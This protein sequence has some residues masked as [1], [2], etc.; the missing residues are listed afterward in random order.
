MADG[1]MRERLDVDLSTLSSSVR[2]IDNQAVAAEGRVSALQRRL[3][4]TEF[5]LRGAE[6][7]LK[8]LGKAIALQLGRELIEGAL[9]EGSEGIA[10][11]AT[12][13]G[14][15]FYAGG[16]I[17][18]GIAFVASSVREIKKMHDDIVKDNERLREAL[19]RSGREFHE[20]VLAEIKEFWTE[21]QE[22]VR[23]EIKARVQGAKDLDYQTWM[24]GRE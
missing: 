2:G 15:A 1:E 8:A 11:I 3:T 14:S 20:G 13:T 17:A 12:T 7:R 21:Q 19:E 16:P 10:N 24:M 23:A 4:D 22:I 18:A 5:Q 6:R 9:P